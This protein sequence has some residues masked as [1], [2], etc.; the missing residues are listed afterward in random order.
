MAWVLYIMRYAIIYKGVLPERI[1]V[2]AS[3]VQIKLDE[4]DIATLRWVLEHMIDSHAEIIESKD[5]GVCV[6]DFERDLEELCR[7]RSKID[8]DEGG[9]K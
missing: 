4:K 3:M 9:E 8:R 2:V 7:L 1:R 5:K 6:E